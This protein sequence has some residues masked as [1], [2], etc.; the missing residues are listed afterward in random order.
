MG[1]NRKNRHICESLL[2]DSVWLIYNSIKKKRLVCECLSMKKECES[3]K[4]KVFGVCIR[5]ENDC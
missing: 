5:I 2:M 3:T 1:M 4:K